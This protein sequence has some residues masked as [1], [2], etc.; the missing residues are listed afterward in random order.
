MR[1]NGYDLPKPNTSGKGP[2][3]DSS[4]IN[5]ND[6]KFKAA[7][8]KCQSDLRALRPQGAPGGTPPASP[9]VDQ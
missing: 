6:P 3:F 9:P 8:A 4:K 5:R 1:K 7:V 2:V